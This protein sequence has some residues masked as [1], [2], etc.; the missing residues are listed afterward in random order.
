MTNI[1]LSD[2]YIIVVNY[3]GVGYARISKNQLIELCNTYLHTTIDPI[4]E[5]C[6]HGFEDSDDCP[7]C[8][9]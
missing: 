6:P 1:K 7:D 9:H 3:D 8:R 4:D 5:L 2:A